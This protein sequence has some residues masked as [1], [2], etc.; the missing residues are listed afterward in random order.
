MGTST[1]RVGQKIPKE[2]LKLAKQQIKAAR[3]MKK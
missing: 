2:I 1:V 3:K